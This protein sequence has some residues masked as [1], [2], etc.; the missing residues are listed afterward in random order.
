V[1]LVHGL[2]TVVSPRAPLEDESVAAPPDPALFEE[3][4]L[5]ELE[6]LELELAPP[7]GGVVG[8]VIA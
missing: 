7:E 2:K 4:E 1:S 8:G 6:E 3:L 5:E